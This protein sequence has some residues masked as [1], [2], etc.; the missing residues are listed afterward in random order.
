MTLTLLTSLLT[1]CGG[2][3]DNCSSNLGSLVGGSGVCDPNTSANLAPLAFAGSDQSVLTQ[4]VV[5]LDASNSRDPEGQ[6]LT[7][8]WQL[9]TKPAGSEAALTSNTSVNPTFTA[10]KSGL[11]IAKLVVNDGTL[12]SSE[13][14]VTILAADENAAPVAN[15]GTNQSVLINSI[16]TLDGSFSS[17][18][19]RDPLTYT[20]KFESIPTGSTASL[21]STSA[22][23][24]TF[25]ADKTGSYVASL[26]VSDGLLKS[27]YIMVTVNVS[28]VNAAPI[29]AI[30]ANQTVA[31][32]QVVTLDG[33]GSSDADR[34]PLTYKWV[35]ISQPTGGTA[36]LSS[37]VAKQP[38]LT[39]AL[40]GNYVA[41][42]VVNDGKADS[43]YAFTTITAVA[44]PVA[45]ATVKSG[46][47]LAP[48]T[49]NVASGTALTF[50]AST[51]ADP[52]NLALTYKW[53]LAAAPTAN[54][55]ALA[56]D[57]AVKSTFTP[58]ATGNYVITLVVNNGTANSNTV[59][60]LLSVL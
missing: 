4:T 48:V 26:I 42:L 18:A 5:K 52:A 20:W 11:Y 21:S 37:L 22:V 17:D 12:N 27:D 23:R 60:L 33:S 32:N 46:A 56:T 53:T 55:E 7:Y 58:V 36:A 8:I 39:T 15:A 31:L 43:N 2:G 10:D 28:S 14:L 50:D 41:S 1:A 13:T 45:K 34:D 29:A 59:T 35:L 30:G 9:K 51:S 16:V 38:T 40:A 57:T 44:A 49:G 47:P 25:K 19:N 6:P 3:G 24:P 54:A